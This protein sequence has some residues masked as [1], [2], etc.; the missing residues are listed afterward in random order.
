MLP[1][2]RKMNIR[3]VFMVQISPDEYPLFQSGISDARLPPCYDDWLSTTMRSHRA[4]LSSG[5]TTTA[6][7]V[8]WDDFIGYAK[9]LGLDPS[10]ALLTTF[11]LRKCF[12]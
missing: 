10:Y 4:H 11:N 5:S 6:V 9:R 12:A 1:T 8:C 3:R 7:T 2:N